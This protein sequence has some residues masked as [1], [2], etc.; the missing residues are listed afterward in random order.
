[1]NSLN[2]TNFTD[3][4]QASCYQFTDVDVSRGGELQQKRND[5]QVQEM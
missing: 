4:T 1:M 5:L 3:S 2:R